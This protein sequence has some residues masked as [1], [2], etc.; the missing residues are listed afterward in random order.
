METCIDLSSQ[1]NLTFIIENPTDA[2]VWI[3]PLY[4]TFNFGIY[5]EDGK[6]VA[7]KSTRHLKGLASEYV[8]IEK[9]S[10]KEFKWL[11]DFF[12]NYQLEINK[13]YYLKCGYE[14]PHLRRKDKRKLNEQNI[15]LS[16]NRFDGKSNLFRMCKK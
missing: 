12:D 9:K 8:K 6:I 1:N 13:M 2:D 14:P 3:N 7:R 16:D 10:K 5:S 11:A 15:R 4:L